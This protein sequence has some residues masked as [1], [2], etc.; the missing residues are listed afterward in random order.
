ME[1]VDTLEDAP[2]D[3]KEKNGKQPDQQKSDVA[4]YIS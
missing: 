1:A 3:A 2:T 4:E